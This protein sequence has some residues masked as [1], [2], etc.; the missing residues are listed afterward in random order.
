MDPSWVAE[1]DLTATLVHTYRGY[2][3]VMKMQAPE[4]KSLRRGGFDDKYR[5]F[6]EDAK[7]KADTGAWLLE[8]TN[9]LLPITDDRTGKIILRE[10]REYQQIS[11][12]LKVFEG[13]RIP[14][15]L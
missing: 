4:K 7:Q 5:L 13:G 10:D 2:K 12:S 11:R 3:A 8:S 6:V 9:M 14:T 15:G 1:S